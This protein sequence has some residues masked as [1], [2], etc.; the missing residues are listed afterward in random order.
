MQNCENGKCTAIKAV[1][2]GLTDSS[3]STLFLTTNL[4]NF[5]FKCLLQVPVPCDNFVYY[6]QTLWRIKVKIHALIQLL[7]QIIAPFSL[8]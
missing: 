3:T 4:L 7:S 8:T 1:F 6:L 2:F 5:L